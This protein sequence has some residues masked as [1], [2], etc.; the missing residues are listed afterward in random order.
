MP[1]PVCLFEESQ[2]EYLE[3]VFSDVL[4]NNIQK[5]EI[6]GKFIGKFP[7]FKTSVRSLNRK[8]EIWEK[9]NL[10]GLTKSTS[11]ISLNEN[12][13]NEL[14]KNCYSILQDPDPIVGNENTSINQLKRD[15]SSYELI[16]NNKKVLRSMNSNHLQRSIYA[17]SFEELLCNQ[18]VSNTSYYRFDLNFN[19]ILELYN[20]QVLPIPGDGLCF[21]SCVRLFFALILNTHWNL[22][23]VRAKI[24][25][26]FMVDIG[27]HKLADVFCSFM[28]GSVSVLVFMKQCLD[29]YFSGDF[30]SDFVD[31]IINRA[32][33]I[34]R[35]DIYFVDVSAA[36]ISLLRKPVTMGGNNYGLNKILVSR[37][38]NHYELLLPKHV[39]VLHSINSIHHGSEII[40]MP[41]NSRLNDSAS[42]REMESV[43]QDERCDPCTDQDY[44]NRNTDRHTDRSQ[45]DAS[46]KR[47]RK[48]KSDTYRSAYNDDGLVD[49]SQAKYQKYDVGSMTAVCILCNRLNFELE[50]TKKSFKL[51]CHHGK[52]SGVIPDLVGLVPET[53]KNLLTS[54]IFPDKVCE[55]FK[56][57]IRKYNNALS[58]ASTGCDVKSFNK[59]NQE[60]TDS[61]L[62][63]H[64]IMVVQGEFMHNS[65]TLHSNR[66]DGLRQYGAVYTLDSEE[67][68]EERMR[69]PYNSGLEKDVLKLLGTMLDRCNP[70]SQ[71]YKRMYE[72]EQELIALYGDTM[73]RAVMYITGPKPH[74]HPG[75]FN[76]V[77]INSEIAIVYDP[78]A[79]G[80]IRLEEY[81]VCVYP[82]FLQGVHVNT[83]LS[84]LNRVTDPLCYSLLYP[85]GGFGYSPDIHHNPLYS[86]LTNTKVTQLQFYS[87]QM[88]V[89]NETFSH[90]HHSGKLFQQYILD[91][92]K[93]T[94]SGR[95]GY[96]ELNQNKLRV[97]SYNGLLEYIHHCECA[98]DVPLGSVYILPSTHVGS[99]RYMQQNYSD[100]MAVMK[101]FGKP[102]FFV[103]F[104][105]NPKWDEITREI[106]KMEGKFRPNDRPDIIARVYKLKLDE[107]MRDL[108]DRNCLGKTVAHVHT[109]EYQKRGLPHAHILLTVDTV[110]KVIN[111]QDLDDLICAEI[112][113][114]GKNPQLYDIV[115]AN[116]VHGP[117]GIHNM[118]RPCMNNDKKKCSKKYP[119]KFVESTSLNKN[120]FPEY[121]RRDNGRTIILDNSR[122]RVIDNRD[123]VPYCPFLTLKY[124]SH[125]NV[126]YCASIKA[127]KYLYK[128]VYKGGDC[129]NVVTETKHFYENPITKRREWN[130]IKT[131]REMKYC[132]SIE[133][134][135]RLYEFPIHSKSHSVCRLAVHL[136]NENMCVIN[137][138]K[139]VNEILKDVSTKMTTLTGWFQLNQTD[140]S[141]RKLLYKEIP[142]YYVWNESGD[143]K[144]SWTVRKRS[145][146]KIIGRIHRIKPNNKRELYYMWLLLDVVRG[147]TCYEDL[148]TYDGVCFKTFEEA[149][150]KRG[151]I[152]DNAHLKNALNEAAL[153]DHPRLMRQLFSTICMNNAVDCLQLWKSFR[154]K[155]CEDYIRKFD[156]QNL[157][158]TDLFEDKRP[159]NC[160]HSAP[161][162]ECKFFNWLSVSLAL[163]DLNRNFSDFGKTTVDFNLSLVDEDIIM[164]FNK[165]QHQNLDNN[166]DLIHQF[167]YNSVSKLNTGQKLIFD[168]IIESFQ[169]Y[170]RGKNGD[171][172]YLAGF[173]GTGKSF[174]I[175]CINQA[176]KKQKGNVLI[177]SWSGMVAAMFESGRTMHNTFG[178]SVPCIDN[179]VPSVT[180]Y[181]SRG[182]RL[183]DADVIIIDE[184][185]QPPVFVY[186]A[187][188]TL[189]RSIKQKDSCFGGITVLM[190]GDFR[191][192]LPI[193]RNATPIKII[194]SC[195]KNWKYWPI[196]RK[197]KLVEHMRLDP[198]NEEFSEFL[199]N[200]G[201][202]KIP[203]L[204]SKTQDYNHKDAIIL[205]D[206]LVLNSI[207]ESNLIKFVFGSD[208]NIDVADNLSKAI[209]TPFNEEALMISEA[210]LELVKGL[211]R[212]YFS[213]DNVT[214]DDTEDASMFD[215]LDAHQETPSGFPPHKLNLKVGCDV[216]LIKNIN[217]SSGF[218]NGTLLTVVKL[219]DNLILAK[220]KNGPYAGREIYLS[221]LAFSTSE[222]LPFEL[223]RVQFPVR[224]AYALTIDKAQ[225]QTFD[226]VG[227]YLPRSVFSHG[228][229]YVALSRVRSFD[230]IKVLVKPTRHQGYLAGTGTYTTNIV[231]SQ[232]LFD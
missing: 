165:I 229:L 84:Y 221:K 6:F 209:L 53:L 63:P 20:L 173:G 179:T 18:G 226:R 30:D 121:R 123:I 176:I 31:E 201:D 99:D 57:N 15:A 39:S 8:F 142:N 188:D 122:M 227:L 162:Y 222:N 111:S 137:P 24:E 228:Q 189:L 60:T 199:L 135:W 169:S 36:G 155:L 12:V 110:D 78:D 215:I 125:I 16:T 136:E 54:K 153:E 43:S 27:L 55:N 50:R 206:R 28:P 5:S 32:C 150:Q 112:P 13:E 163:R 198:G 143:F 161:D 183:L 191:Q 79:D 133:A 200:V 102:D 129:A 154:S 80:A 224:L 74:Q 157:L 41:R 81:D 214:F 145:G 151:L 107:L 216:M 45:T 22:S 134:T 47:K 195:L 19:E 172:F 35:I 38:N 120:G 61:N 117:C 204:K 109:I 72:L 37:R 114:P 124:N 44:G 203:F 118:D 128:Y 65:S 184:C 220:I 92:W 202:G 126:E 127:V 83:K 91:S 132:S 14:D 64:D 70:Y 146:D 21:I 225:G 77:S 67:A 196:V 149:C 192:T 69:N 95:L 139:D 159:I 158:S 167:D 208:K 90:F 160:N 56:N 164:D 217:I 23:D 1:R 144:K 148:R 211:L 42:L 156:V 152:K 210:V 40:R 177:T 181:S 82:R 187:C 131:Y 29:R 62:R 98:A 119:K 147:A 25:N 59:K 223:E 73:S 218:C 2:L 116:M 100:A 26:Y 89:P 97:E 103:T 87:Y 76:T 168:A 171:M 66:A 104:T 46:Y 108:T 88:A 34:F 94:E 180:A 10:N 207:N 101:A 106:N 178:L 33:D 193:I 51:C 11:L 170:R 141:A 86:S 174:L 17:D 230:A 96:L 175:N 212:S 49:E 197:F 205:D 232:V 9:A 213:E 75:R 115:K 166:A 3:Q 52:L 4:N 85:F 130:E 182:K 219:L 138:N 105:C 7:N 48:N 71:A 58:H 186:E 190:T 231:H 68:T 185:S 93:K 194:N 140:T 113:D